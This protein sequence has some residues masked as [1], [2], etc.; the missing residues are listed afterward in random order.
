MQSQVR[1]LLRIG[2]RITARAM[3]SDAVR[4]YPKEP[5]VGIGIVVLRHLEPSPPEVLLIQRGK[6]PSMGQWSIPGGS[7]ELGETI[8]E[9]AIRETLEE[10]GII[11]RNKTPGQ[12]YSLDGALDS[13]VA[14]AGVDV[15]SRDKEDE[16]DYHYAII[17]VA[18]VPEDPHQEPKAGDDAA[19]VKWFPVEHVRAMRASGQAVVNL[20]QVTEE[21]VRR[22][23]ITH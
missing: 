5:R 1:S 11:L 19:D 12:L 10:T 13:P 14:Y 2:S 20:D 7:L 17:E 15:I 6:P 23:K 8:I 22:F 16:I 3:N 18:A 21:A 9:C 4:N